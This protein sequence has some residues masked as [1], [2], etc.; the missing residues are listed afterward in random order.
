MPGSLPTPIKSEYL[1]EGGP[2]PQYFPKAPQEILMSGQDRE[3]LPYAAI[4]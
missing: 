4:D 2:G 1:H 3:L